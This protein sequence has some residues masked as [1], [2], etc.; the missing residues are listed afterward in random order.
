MPTGSS[1]RAESLS[2][3]SGVGSGRPSYLC[4]DAVQASEPEDLSAPQLP[5]GVVDL[6]LVLIQLLLGHLVLLGEL[7]R[8]A[9]EPQLAVGNGGDHLVPRKQGG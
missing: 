2:S 7:P 9:Q 8:T 1:M 4:L 5:L 6:L 3:V